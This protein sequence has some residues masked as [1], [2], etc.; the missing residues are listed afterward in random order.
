MVPIEQ[1]FV[2]RLSGYLDLGFSYQKAHNAAQLSTGARLSYRGPGAETTFD[3]STFIEDRDD[4]E[5]TSR[6][7]PLLPSDCFWGIAGAPDCS[8]GYDRSD[9]LD[10]S[11]RGRLVGFG[12]REM[13]PNP[14]T[15]SFRVTGGLVLT[16]E[17]YFSADSTH[18]RRRRRWQPRSLSSV[19]LRPSQT[20]RLADQPGYFPVLRS[21]GRVQMQNDFRV[22][23]ELVKDFMLT[24]TVF[25]TF[26][27]KP[28][29]RRLQAR[30]RDHA[31]DQLDL[32]RSCFGGWLT[33]T[34]AP[35]PRP[36]PGARPASNS[37]S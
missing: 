31:R 30:L 25:D 22:S 32:L 17:R 15:S 2:S 7:S 20:R 6:L 9:E 36:A 1:R 3:F 11:G 4:A 19:P 27:S 5:E 13:V 37:R 26:D 12:A 14:T 21:E 24:G 8:L 10:L 34:S 28:Q 29:A 18:R 23:Y 16:R 33:T 35:A